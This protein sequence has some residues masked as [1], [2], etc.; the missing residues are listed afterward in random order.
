VKKVFGFGL[1]LLLMTSVV[2]GEQPKYVDSPPLTKVVTNPVGDVRS[3][4][5]LQVPIITWG[6]DIATIYANGNAVATAKGG[7]F[8]NQGLNFK[9]VLEDDFAKQVAAFRG[10][11]SPYLRGTMGMINMATEVLSQDP[12]T[13]PVI[14]YQLTW[15]TGGDC[16][17]VK[18]GIK[19]VADLKGKT[20][21]LQAYGPHVDWM[22]T[23]LADAGLSPTDV[24]IKWVQNLTVTPKDAVNNP[25]NALRSDPGV[26]AVFVISPD[27][28]ALT[29]NGTVGT[30]AEDSVKGAR[31]LMST[32]TADKVIADVYAVRADFLSRYRSEV[33]K[34]AKGLMAAEEQL[35]NLVASKDAKKAEYQ[36]TFSAAAK[37][38]MDSPNVADAEG[39]YGDCRYVGHTGNVKFFATPSEPRNLENITNETQEAFLVLGLLSKKVA[40]THANWDYAVLAAGLANVNVASTPRFDTSKVA[41]AIDRREKQGLSQ[42]GELFSFY[43]YFEPNQ[44]SF[45][46]EKYSDKFAQ[47]VDL[48]STHGGAVIT[49][50]GHSDPLGFLKSQKSGSS[51]I[52]LGRIRQSA[53]NLSVTRANALRDGILAYAQAKSI[54]LD[55]SQFVVIGHGIEKPKH[56]NPRTELEWKGNMRVEFRIIQVEAEADVFRPL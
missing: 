15:S 14:V 55:Q 50:E 41:T 9:L 25:A 24:K 12:R 32:K 44:N 35:R 13:Q 36:T 51:D 4:G 19:T 52:V 7:V 2:F 21:A 43:V 1:T 48:A 56:A 23:E 40:V 45:P 3:G 26:D 11:Q 31:I 6:G 27:A 47:V 5:A 38:L 20:I 22:T 10:G 46:A 17:V 30:G 34:F 42:E 18:D 33:E 37:V 29:S 49:V 8:A 53:K 54:A 16:L 39:L 28:F